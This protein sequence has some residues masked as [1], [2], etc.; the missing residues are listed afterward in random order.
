VPSPFDL[1]EV[2]VALNQRFRIDSELR[3]GGQGVVYRALRTRRPDGTTTADDV[4]LKLHLDPAQDERVEREIAVMDGVRHPNLARLVEH[5]LIQVSGRDVRFAA[6]EYIDGTPLD[7]LIAQ[8]PIPPRNVAIIGRDVARALDYVWTNHLVV[9]RDVNPKNIM[10]RPQHQDAVL[11]DLGAARHM[12]Q[13]TIT[14]AGAT[15]GT[16]GY[17]S[18]EQCRTETNLTCLSDIFCL[19]ITLQEALVGRHP[20]FGN[21]LI[22]AAS[23]PPT[24]NLVPGAPAMLCVIIDRMYAVRAADVLPESGVIS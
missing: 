21:Q 17:L 15:Y 9:H 6:W 20:T 11:I 13:A 18:P 1:G 12:T 14:A 8:G 24:A 4:A 19:A 3:I 23:P 2:T 16:M 7:R 10:W 5:G 22:L